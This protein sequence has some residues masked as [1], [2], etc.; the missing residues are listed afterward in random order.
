ML[1]T[2]QARKHKNKNTGKLGKQDRKKKKKKHAAACTRGHIA[3]DRQHI[4]IIIIQ[5]KKENTEDKE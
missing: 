5:R 4:K 1:K 2:T 3:T